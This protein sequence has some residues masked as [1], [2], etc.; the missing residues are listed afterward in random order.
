MAEQE[1]EI[2]LVVSGEE[3]ATLSTVR[4]LSN[5]LN[6]FSKINRSL[7]LASNIRRSLNLASNIRRG[8]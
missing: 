5:G 7:N 2:E 6:L 4:K 3:I 8:F 1:L